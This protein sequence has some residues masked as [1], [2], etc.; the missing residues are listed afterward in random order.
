MTSEFF[1]NLAKLFGK[2]CYYACAAIL[3]VMQFNG[4][5]EEFFTIKKEL[6]VLLWFFA[7]I[8]FLD[9]LNICYLKY[10]EFKSKK[11]HEK[12]KIKNF[13]NSIELVKLNHKN[14]IKILYFLFNL[15]VHGDEN[16]K[17]I[18]NISRLFECYDSQEFELIEIVSKFANILIDKDNKFLLKNKN[19]IIIFDKEFYEFLKDYFH[20][21]PQ[22]KFNIKSI[23]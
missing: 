5:L 14:G 4:K 21:N 12:Q 20:K 22:K 19:Q 11:E 1:S 3:I 16:C 2:K 6:H 9:I 23:I 8:A 18:K 17:S 13:L 10:K 7:I 15:P